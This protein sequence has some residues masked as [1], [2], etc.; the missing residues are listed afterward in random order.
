MISLERTQ[1]SQKKKKGKRLAREA[2]QQLKG[3]TDQIKGHSNPSTSQ[4]P[5]EKLASSPSLAFRQEHVLRSV[6]FLHGRS[7][8][9]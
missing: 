5:L 4:L 2:D 9:G 7:T 6:S 8:F 3:T 1:S